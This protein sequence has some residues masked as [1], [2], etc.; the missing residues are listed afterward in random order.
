[1]KWKIYDC[2][3]MNAVRSTS[4][5]GKIYSLLLATTIYCASDK[6]MAAIKYTAFK[7]CVKNNK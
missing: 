2:D 7:V 6:L 3:R 4:T 1:M 5:G